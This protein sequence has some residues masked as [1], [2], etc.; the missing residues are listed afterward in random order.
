MKTRKYFP[1]VAAVL[2]VII[3]AGTVA[4][5][6]ALR[7]RNGILRTEYGSWRKISLVLKT[8]DEN[9]VDS[10]DRAKVMDAALSAA[11]KALD[12][13]SVYMPPVQLEESESDLAADFGGIGIQFNVP[14]D[15]AVVIEVIPGGPSEKIGILPGDRILEVDGVNIAGVKC[16]QDSMVRKMRGPS[17]TKVRITVGRSGERTTFDIRRAVIPN[18]SIEASFVGAD[19]VGYIRLSKFSR[20]TF[21]EFLSA[22]AELMASGMNSLVLDLRQNSGGYFDQSI[23]IANLFLEK[24]STIVFTEGRT[25]PRDDFKADGKGFLKN[26][27]TAVL[28]DEGSA[29]SSE[30]LAGALQDNGKAVIVGRRSFGK[31]LVQEPFNFTDGSGFRLTVSRFHTPSGRCIQKPYSDRYE[32]E[33]YERY[34]AGE[35]LDADSMRVEKGGIIPDVFVPV[36]TTKASAFYT[37]CYRKATITRFAAHWADSNRERLL[38]VKNFTELQRLIDSSN[39]EAAFLSYAAGVDGLK[40][41][42]GEWKKEKEYMMPQVRALAGRYSRLGERAYY[43]MYLPSDEV[44]LAALRAIGR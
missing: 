23:H 36:D 13:H 41:K 34:G 4:L 3:G 1:L 43:Q 28:I 10:V 21:T 25:R 31:G 38:E 42:A 15:T 26:I 20:S 22:S 9:Y 2:G 32:Y 18:R 17:G 11:L 29:S 14:S 8:I 6:G 19:S 35:M 33:V 24:D 39:L 37:A 16:P 30:I 5:V 27:R 7:E 12:P 40:P 44:Y